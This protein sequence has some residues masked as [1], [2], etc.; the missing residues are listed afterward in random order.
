VR[1][2]Q[3]A[4]Q[5]RAQARQERRP[6]RPEARQQHRDRRGGTVAP[7]NDGTDGS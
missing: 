1:Q 4:E 7:Q 2:K 5:S 3:R 6:N